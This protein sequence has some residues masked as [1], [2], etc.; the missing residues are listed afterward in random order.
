MAIYVTDEDA[1]KA[2][3]LIAEMKAILNAMRTIAD[4]TRAPQQF[5]ELQDRHHDIVVG[6]GELYRLSS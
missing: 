4:A 2:Q 3:V 1:E 6:L 5:L